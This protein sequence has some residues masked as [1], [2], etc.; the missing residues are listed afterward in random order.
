MGDVYL[1]GPGSSNSKL[2]GYGFNPRCQ[3]GGDFSSLLCVQTG[4]GVHL[5]SYK[6]EYWGFLRNKRQPIVGLAALPFLSVMAVY[7]WTLSSTSPVGL[8]AL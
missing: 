8:N 5:A 6:N 4:P 2:L 7:T 1:C 3:R